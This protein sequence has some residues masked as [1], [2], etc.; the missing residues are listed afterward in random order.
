ML[1]GLDIGMMKVVVVVT[2]T[3]NASF[4][5]FTILPSD[6]TS[7]LVV[8]M[9]QAVSLQ[10]VSSNHDF[11]K[12]PGASPTGPFINPGFESS[13]ST[14][15]STTVSTIYTTTTT[16]GKCPSSASAQLLTIQSLSGCAIAGIVAAI[17]AAAPVLF[18]LP[19]S[20]WRRRRHQWHS[21]LSVL[22]G[23]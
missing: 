12:A 19:L 20:V 10:A 23:R 4:R 11:K 7:N 1:E 17:V 14:S 9:M 18:R 6:A 13:L 16:A 3:E 15:A 5:T 22:S 8:D 21:L 2:A